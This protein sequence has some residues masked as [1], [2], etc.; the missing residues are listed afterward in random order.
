[1]IFCIE[2]SS[3]ITSRRHHG[4]DTL[5][6][7]TINAGVEE[8]RIMRPQASNRGQ[9]IGWDGWH[10]PVNL[11]GA[12]ISQFQQEQMKCGHSYNIMLERRP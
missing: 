8:L 11:G 9:R 6:F 3:Q 5:S 12:R 10:R 2:I 1:L 4:G 7:G